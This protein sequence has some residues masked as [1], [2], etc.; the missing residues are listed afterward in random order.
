M[1]EFTKEFPVKHKMVD[2][3]FLP[4]PLNHHCKCPFVVKILRGDGVP[5]EQYAET[6]PTLHSI[7]NGYIE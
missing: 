1:E 3:Y 7:Q 4:F 6:M 2:L 5:P